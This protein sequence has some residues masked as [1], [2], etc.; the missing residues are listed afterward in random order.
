MAIGKNDPTNPWAWGD[1]P[2]PGLS[3][4]QPANDNADSEKGSSNDIAKA[5]INAAMSIFSTPPKNVRIIGSQG[6]SGYLG[7]SKESMTPML[8]ISKPNEVDPITDTNT[9]KFGVPVN[10]PSTS[11][12]I[13]VDEITLNRNCEFSNAASTNYCEF[14][15]IKLNSVL[16]DYN[17]LISILNGGVY[18]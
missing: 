3:H 2:T 12:D 10:R 14:S 7:S 1:N 6:S 4:T 8:L 18:I 5:G 16:G 17:E 11:D 9:R 15:R 13:T